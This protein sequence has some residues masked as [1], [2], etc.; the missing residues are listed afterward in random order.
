[1]SLPGTAPMEAAMD[2][3]PMEA[4]PKLKGI[5]PVFREYSNLLCPHGKP[6][7]GWLCPEP[8]CSGQGLCE[9]GKQRK[10]FCKECSPARCPLCNNG[11]IYAWGNLESHI[12]GTKL[13]SGL[14]EGEKQDAYWDAGTQRGYIHLLKLGD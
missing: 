3:S 4:A 14:S 13:H 5:S 9:H 2:T 12:Y 6:G 1:M 7:N 8:G 11:R 10:T